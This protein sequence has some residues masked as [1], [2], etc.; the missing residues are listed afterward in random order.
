MFSGSSL[1]FAGSAADMKKAAQP[2]PSSH[3]EL[4]GLA[5]G[6]AGGGAGPSSLAGDGGDTIGLGEQPC[7]ADAID[8]LSR[9]QPGADRAIRQRNRR[10][11]FPLPALIPTNGGK[12]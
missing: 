2:K 9:Y 3:D 1:S 5:I 7:L 10:W 6:L 12:R 8:V 11:R 4:D